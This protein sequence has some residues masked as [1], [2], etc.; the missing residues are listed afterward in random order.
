MLVPS[1]DTPD[2]SKALPELPNLVAR[3]PGPDRGGPEEPT[4]ITSPNAERD[5]PGR[6]ALVAAVLAVVG[7]GL[8]LL[9]VVRATRLSA[10]DEATHIDYAW[11][12]AD[13]RLPTTGAPLSDYTLTSWAC[14]GQANIER[15]PA[16]SSDH[17][18][19]SFP[20][21]GQQ[22]NGFHPP[23][24]Y[25]LTGW[26]AR[27]LAAI[28][29]QDFVTVA[30]ALGSLWLFAAM[31]GLYLTLRYWRVQWR[32]ALLAGLALPVIPS[33]LHASS[34]VTNDAAAAV[35]GV[36]AVYVLG[37]TMVHERTGWLVPTVLTLLAASTKT[38]NSLGLLVIAGIL[39]LAGSVRWRRSGRPAGLPLLRTGALMIAA[40]ATVELV[41][42]RISASRTI[43]DWQNP[44]GGVHTSEFT[45]LPFDE[46]LPTLVSGFPLGS[47]YYL[48][49]AVE[50]ASIVA[51]VTVSSL[52]LTVSSFL[53]LAVFGRGSARWQLSAAVM[54]GCLAYP[55]LVQAT[56]L[57]RTDPSNSYFWYLSTR[58]GTSLIPMAIAV[59]I[60]IADQKRL[61]VTSAAVVGAGLV[62]VLISTAGWG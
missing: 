36:A 57:S 18:A 15:L 43:P 28:T 9:S 21:E 47:F 14:R 8:S 44:I 17:P 19:A 33:V 20:A 6:L 40:A 48:D 60:M 11:L 26:A 42:G 24:Y 51:W 1:S 38:V 2:P 5:S 46:W 45:G 53:G 37:R 12:L 3:T 61:R 31:F 56:L 29:G 27:P 39:V 23:L 50:S 55:L 34:T 54:I 25:A 41:W 22:Y 59:L 16:C 4:L 52:L 62:A 35:C 32:Y 49:P 7:I 30:R 10:F 13:F 58:Y